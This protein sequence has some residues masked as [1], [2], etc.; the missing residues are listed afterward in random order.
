MILD[1]MQI[2]EVKGP[3]RVL[4][5]QGIEYLLPHGFPSSAVWGSW[6]REVR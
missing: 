3:R 1:P 4:G 2:A 5:G 6:E